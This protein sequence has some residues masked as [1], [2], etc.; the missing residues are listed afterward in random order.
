MPFDLQRV[1]TGL[2]AGQRQVSTAA[3][4]SAWSSLRLLVDLALGEG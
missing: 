1:W 2:L 4:C 3:L